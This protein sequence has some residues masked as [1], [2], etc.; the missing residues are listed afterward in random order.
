M[1]NQVTALFA[2]EDAKRTAGAGNAKYVNIG[3][4]PIPS[5]MLLRLL[6]P[7]VAGSL[8]CATKYTSK[9]KFQG[10]VDSDSDTDDE[11]TVSYP[12]MKTWGMDDYVLKAIAPYW[13]GTEEE[14]NIYARPYYFRP[15]YI[16]G[17][18]VVSLPYVE[19]SPPESPIRLVSFSSSIQAQVRT[20]LADPD[21]EYA[22]YDLERG[23][24]FRVAK[25]QLGTWPNYSQSGFVMKESAVPQS[26]L[27]AIEKYGLPDLD[28][29]I[30]EPPTAEVREMIK[31]MYHASLAGEPFQN[32]LWGGTFRAYAAY[33][34]NKD[35]N[36]TQRGNAKPQPA[37]SSNG[38]SNGAD[39]DPQ[40]ILA[41]L[42][43]K[44]QARA[45]Q[46]QQEATAD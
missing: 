40:G 45:A 4:M 18:L 27:D 14:K 13:K 28:A 46:P 39:N 8:P 37:P 2:A 25:V 21:M 5:N 29:E 43:A 20:G 26:G 44:T 42:K 38:A 19:Q 22:P 16:Y 7:A 34:S 6:P 15:S 30:G 9:F 12:C 24:S 11:V 3:L 36:T 35:S 41:K 1:M 10:I 31:A 32:K 17:C 33:G 23:R